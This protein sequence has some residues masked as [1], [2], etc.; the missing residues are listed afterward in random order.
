LQGVELLQDGKVPEARSRLAKALKL[1]PHNVLAG[2]MWKQLDGDPVAI[3][4]KEYFN[5]KV[6]P[7][8]TLS[9]I[10]DRFF[11][12]KYMFHVLARYNNITA[13]RQLPAGLIIK[14]PG[15]PPPP[16]K[17]A[18][19][20]P[21]PAEPP[22]RAATAPPTPREGEPAVRAYDNAIQAFKQAQQYRQSGK[23]EKMLELLD[24][25]HDY[26]REGA[27]YPQTPESTA[28]RDQIKRPLADA[29]YREAMRPYYNQQLDL[30]IALFERAVEVDPDHPSAADYLRK[31]KDLKARVSK[32]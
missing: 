31:A 23:S 22:K 21:P 6:M 28:K 16:P 4:G 9:R 13:P 7:G 17:I 30:A 18:P 3:L 11:G 8:D 1:D 32:F 5:Y 25:A 15:K 26:Y 14:I 12:D 2:T 24:K 29:Y 20:P 19:A 27:R 10:A